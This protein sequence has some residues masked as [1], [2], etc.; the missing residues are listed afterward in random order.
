MLVTESGMVTECKDEQFS[1]ARSTILVTESGMIKFSPFDKYEI[2][3]RL[4]EVYRFSSN[5][6]KC[7]E[8]L[9]TLAG[10]FETGFPLIIVT[11]SGMVTD[12][13]YEQLENALRPMLVTESG[14]VTDC[15][16]LQNENAS[17]PMLVTE[18]GMVTDCKD[19]HHENA[20]SQMLLVPC[21][22]V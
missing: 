14:M 4:S 9:I 6:V 10:Q 11:D 8:R 3:F 19:K 1:N 17:T 2:S 13:K 20:W 22:I 21:L 12:C 16:D 7:F 5:I 15:K 18:S